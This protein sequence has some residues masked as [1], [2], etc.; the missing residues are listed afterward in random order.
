MKDIQKKRIAELV[1]EGR[2]GSYIQKQLKKEK[3]GVRRTEIFKLRAKI[4]QQP[5]SSQKKFVS[6]PTKY[7]SKKEK[8]KKERIL[9]IRK[10]KRKEEKLPKRMRDILKY[11][12]KL[13]LE[14]IRSD[15]KT[16]SGKELQKKIMKLFKRDEEWVEGYILKSKKTVKELKN[17][18]AL[19]LI[20]EMRNISP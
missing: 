15:L 14:K 7:L 9:K 2:S 8:E 12:E 17:M 13:K 10:E 16:K 4:L 1:R 20:N 19:D 11:E 3:I 6:T 5:I 18:T